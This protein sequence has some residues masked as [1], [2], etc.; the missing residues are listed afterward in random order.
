MAV[1]VVLAAGAVF[2]LGLGW[3]NNPNVDGLIGGSIYALIVCLPGIPAFLLG[4]A[5][6]RRSRS[7]SI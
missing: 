5:C 7:P 2:L 4:R 6:W 1:G 3:S